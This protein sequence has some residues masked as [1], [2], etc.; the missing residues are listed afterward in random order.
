MPRGRPVKSEI[1]QN[2]V[3]ILQYM[4]SG[5]GYDIYRHYVKVFPRCTIEVIYYHLKKGVTLDLFKVEKVRQEEGE[6]SWGPIV[7]KTYYMLG[8]EAK[9]RHNQRIRELFR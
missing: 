6:F 8:P 7:E 3:D 5:Y 4:K 1:R 9:P 2:I